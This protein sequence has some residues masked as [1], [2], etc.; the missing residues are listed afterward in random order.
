MGNYLKSTKTKIKENYHLFTQ[1][2][3]VIA[4]CFMEGN[5]DD[6]S[7]KSV[8]KQ[9]FVS[10]AS[11]SR[12]AKKL[13]FSGYRE[14]VFSYNA[15]LKENRR[16]DQ[17]TEFAIH[18]YQ[19]VLERSYQVVD[20]NQMIRITN[21]LNTSKRVFVYG[22]GSSALAAKE[23]C[24]RFIRLGLDVET[25]NNSDVISLNTNRVNEDCLVI[26]ISV[27]GR[28]EAVLDGLKVAHQKGATTILLTSNLIAS[29]EEFTNEIV[30][31]AHLKNI[32]V[33]NIISPQ[34]PV[35]IMIDVI[36]THYLNH[37]NSDKVESLK[38]I[39]NQIEYKYE[40]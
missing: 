4:D 35:L 12:F 38:Q 33:S 36:Y 31:M 22:I 21:M 8:S 3:R 19:E 6:F 18:K 32:T 9:L 39:L 28:N 40:K 20:N 27:S 13:G 24:L 5:I 10:E 15:N 16:L 29:N 11:L 7:S 26:G 14:F 2:E 23:F 37:N 17:L 34:I 30:L 25:L 1:V